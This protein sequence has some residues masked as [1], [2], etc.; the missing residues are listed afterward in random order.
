MVRSV[1]IQIPAGWPQTAV[2]SEHLALLGAVFGC[3][4]TELRGMEVVSYCAAVISG[5]KNMAKGLLNLHKTMHGGVWDQVQEGGVDSI[6]KV[7]AH[8]TWGDVDKNDP[9][10]IYDFKG[11]DLADIMANKAVGKFDEWLECRKQAHEA[12]SHMVEQVQNNEPIEMINLKDNRK[13]ATGK[14]HNPNKHQ[15]RWDEC[16]NIWRC[17]RCGTG[18]AKKGQGGKCAAKEITKG[19]F[20]DTHYSH[21]L[22]R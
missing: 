6:R 9:K 2:M 20:Q 4:Q 18:C 13:K 14:T 22:I 8:R 3:K 7:K 10:D 17:L 5:F 1:T 16:F 21:K 15:W 11:I 12:L 19:V